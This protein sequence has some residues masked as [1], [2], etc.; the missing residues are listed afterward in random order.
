MV[1]TLLGDCLKSVIG[2]IRD[3]P[4]CKLSPKF[5]LMLEWVNGM[6]EDLARDETFG[7]EG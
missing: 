7:E 6:T 2:K 3:D 4:I 1:L 5:V